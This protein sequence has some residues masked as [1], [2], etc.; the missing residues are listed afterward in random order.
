MPEL[1]EVEHLRRT[2]EASLIGRRIE[3]VRVLRLDV[4]RPE[5]GLGRLFT[6]SARLTPTLARGLLRGDVIDAITRHGK[7]LAIIGRSG[8]VICIHL[9]MSGQVRLIAPSQR[10]EPASHVHVIWSITNRHDEPA[11]RMV[12]RDPRRFGGIWLAESLDH[13]REH[14]WNA[15][16]PDGLTLT[17]NQFRDAMAGSSSP[18]KAALLNQRLI[19]GVGNIY[20]DES[21]FQAKI[22]PQQPAN[23]LDAGQVTRL[24]RAI[25][26]TLRQAVEQGGSTL[27][28]YVDAEGDPGQ[29]AAW[30]QV[31]G[32]SGHA[33]LRC[34]QPL[35][36]MMVAQRT[37]VCC[38]R[39][40][41][42]PKP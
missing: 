9:G 17:R 36:H 26:Q 10:I 25:R 39:C 21:L 1:P 14:R 28:D 19:A 15:I 30:H 16:G 32:R 7:Q 22:H 29:Y 37:T 38:T 18:I 6:P 3:R 8:R 31:Y 41:P 12:F 11:G 33:C 27:R 40:Q 24:H 42:I 34:G 20:A 4:V 35:Q 5:P 13:L 2:L 23:S